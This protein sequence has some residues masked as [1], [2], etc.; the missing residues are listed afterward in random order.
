MDDILTY[1]EELTHPDPLLREYFAVLRNTDPFT[2]VIQEKLS[3]GFLDGLTSAQGELL[4]GNGRR[5]S[6]GVSAWEF[7]S[8]WPGFSLRF[9]LF[10][11]DTRHRSYRRR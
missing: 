4:S 2:K 3:L 11:P 5:P 6:P 1:L 9:E 10:S 8:L 7:S